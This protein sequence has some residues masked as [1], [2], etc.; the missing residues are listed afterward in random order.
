MAFLKLKIKHKLWKTRW[1][2]SAMSQLKLPDH[3]TVGEVAAVFGSSLTILQ[4][5]LTHTHT[6]TRVCSAPPTDKLRPSLCLC[7][8]QDEK[9]QMMTT[10]VWLKQVRKKC[11]TVYL[12][13][14]FSFSNRGFD[15]IKNTI[16]KWHFWR[17]E[18]LKW[19]LNDG[20]Q[21]NHL[22]CWFLQEWND[23]KLSWRPSDYDNVTS[24]RVPSEL[25]W[26]PDIVLYNKWVR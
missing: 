17:R 1:C 12:L 20:S 6:H 21:Q 10:N 3:F 8:C 5:P 24:I 26:V 19:H 18:S 4:K 7:V 22:C 2:T 13:L 14:R 11:V 16:W 23:Y 15:Y 9:N 25:I